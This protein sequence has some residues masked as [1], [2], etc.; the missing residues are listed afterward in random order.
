MTDAARRSFHQYLDEIRAEIVRVGG[1]AVE[2]VPRGTDALL[3]GDLVGADG[4]I[5]RAH[6]VNARTL[7]AEERCYH[8]LATQSPVARDLRQIMTAVRMTAE[9]ERS[10]ALAVN[11]AKAARR[12]YG[13][14][15]DPKLR[16]LITLMSEHAHQLLKL[17]VDAYVEAD[18]PLAAALDD[19]DDMLDLVHADFISTIFEVYATG[20][21]E[22]K[23]A[24]QLAMIGRFYER[25]GDH[26]VNIGRRV[27]Y[28]VTGNL[29]DASTPPPV[30]PV[31][32]AGGDD[33]RS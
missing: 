33:I 3:A 11:I 17:A 9:I 10:H 22:L 15:L 30:R 5:Q 25:I 7:A 18:A 2:A 1:M 13:H 21:T 19:M 28:M 31:A 29:P 8:L 14:E 26:A 6:E 16:G 4:L 32:A 27:Q 12:I 24:V 23:V 20:D